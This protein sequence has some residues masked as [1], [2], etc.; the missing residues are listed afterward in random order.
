MCGAASGDRSPRTCVC[1]AKT[2]PTDLHA[3]LKP[4]RVCVPS[5]KGLFDDCP[6]RHSAVF[7]VRVMVRPVPE[8]ISMGPRTTSGLFGKGVAVSAPLRTG[9]ASLGCVAGSPEATKPAAT[10]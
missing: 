4:T 5:Q 3:L 1:H 7:C 6:Q 2:Q 8:K 9:R 10:C